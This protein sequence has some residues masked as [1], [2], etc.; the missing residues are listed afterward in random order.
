MLTIYSDRH[1]HHHG[2]AELDGTLKPCFEMPR[3]AEMI[4]A[5]VR[6]VGLGDVVAPR[7]FGLDP[8]RRVHDAGSWP[9]WNR[10]WTD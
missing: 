1:H 6:E 4:L 2:T 5:R 10:Q 8:V 7:A 3:R 9:S